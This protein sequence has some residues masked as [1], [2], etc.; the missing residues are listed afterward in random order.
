MTGGS[1]GVEM[2]VATNVNGVNGASVMLYDD[3]LKN[4]ANKIGKNLFI[5]P[6]STHELILVPDTGFM[7]AK[8]I[9]SMVMDVN[10]TQVAADEILSNNVYYFSLDTGSITL[11]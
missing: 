11:A 10:E 6:S 4:F 2:Y 5:L 7:N 3:L 9:K 1:Q 8:D